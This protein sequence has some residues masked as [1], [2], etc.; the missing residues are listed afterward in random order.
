MNMFTDLHLD[1]DDDF[2]FYK[3]FKTVLKI[4]EFYEIQSSIPRKLLPYGYWN[5]GEGLVIPNPLKWTRRGNLEVVI[6]Y[7][8][9]RLIYKFVL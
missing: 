4:W 6:F 3:N 9:V 7:I 5:I 2:F 1:L 8:F